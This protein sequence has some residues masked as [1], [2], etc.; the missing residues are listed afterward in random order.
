MPLARAREG[1]YIHIR[2]MTSKRSS[3]PRFGAARMAGFTPPPPIVLENTRRAK[4]TAPIHQA[5][6]CGDPGGTGRT[7]APA[8]PRQP[9]F[10]RRRLTA[11]IAVMAVPAMAA[12]GDFGALAGDAPGVTGRAEAEVM[13]AGAMA[14]ER[15]G[16]SFPGSAFYN[17]ADPPDAA[18]VALPENDPLERGAAGG[19]EPGALIDAG[20]AA[21]AFIA[22]AGAQFER[23]QTCLAQAVWYEA[24]S[25]SEAGQRA[26][27]QVVLNRVAHPSWPASV[28]GVVYQGAE[29][30]TGCQFSFTCDGS[31]ARRPA[32]LHKGPGWASANRIAAEALGGSVYAAIGH[33]T[34]Y[35]TLWV[36]PYWASTLD[37]V[38]VI[39]AHRFYRSRGSAGESSAFSA[40][41]SGIEPD[42][43][44]L[45]ARTR[46]AAGV[47][48][49]APS[50]QRIRPLPVLETAISSDQATARITP[51]TAAPEPEKSGRTRKEYAR[52]GQWKVNP[53]TLDRDRGAQPQE[54][55]GA[56][57]EASGAAAQDPPRQ[58]P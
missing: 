32:A 47:P 7:P 10:F 4:S 21:A 58:A 34:H 48:A 30:S 5:A 36:D 9:G 43:S 50:A 39:G 49:P 14:F 25:E 24:A 13:L 29:L 11:L 6:A 45:G 22:G 17:L 51:G 38:G 18:L 44:R 2:A 8:A 40:R 28:C 52:A 54:A 42:A 1:A 15:P 27:A 37:P 16:M 41:Y 3:T 57:T 20:P 19:R 12:P 23:A 56:V 53:A 26:V 31:L 55:A 46:V 33:A 35:H